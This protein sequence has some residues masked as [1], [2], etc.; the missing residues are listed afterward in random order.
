MALEWYYKICLLTTTPYFIISLLIF[1]Y[2][3]I[4]RRIF[5]H[6]LIIILIT[7]ILNPLLKSYYQIPPL[8][9]HS[10]F[11]FPSG[12]TQVSSAFWGGIIWYFPNKLVM[13]MVGLVIT[14]IS[15]GLIYYNHHLLIDT[16]GAIGFAIA[17]IGVYVSLEKTLHSFTNYHFL[18]NLS[19]VLI[20]SLLVYLLPTTN[21]FV[22]SAYL[23]LLAWIIIHYFYDQRILFFP[24]QTNLHK[25]IKM[26]LYGTILLLLLILLCQNIVYLITAITFPYSLFYPICAIWV[27]FIWPKIYYFMQLKQDK[28]IN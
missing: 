21:L 14:G 15:G 27:S 2:Y 5:K 9:E 13:L 11:R 24:V 19:I 20:S 12:H 1:S 26:F 6:V 3:C 7:L 23:T 22:Y 17:T 28:L 4:N 25:N 16:V 8:S 10:G 18:F